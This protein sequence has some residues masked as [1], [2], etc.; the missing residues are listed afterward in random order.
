MKAFDSFAMLDAN[1][2]VVGLVI[3]AE[4][5]AAVAA[6]LARL[7]G[8]AQEFMNFELPDEAAQDDPPRETTA[9]DD[10]LREAAQDDPPRA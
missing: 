2:A 10:P 3:P 7:H 1:A 8:L 4:H 6:N 5:R 9:Q